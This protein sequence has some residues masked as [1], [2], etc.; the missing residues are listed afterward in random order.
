MLTIVDQR[1]STIDQLE[2]TLVEGE[3]MI[4]AIRA[5]QA[6][7]LVALAESRIDKV[8]GAKTL[9]EWVAARL[10]VAGDTAWAL[11][12]AA[13]LFAEHVSSA[14]RLAAAE[15]TFDRA[16]ATAKLA[17]S[18]ALE[19][20]LEASRGYDLSS[21]ARLTARHRRLSRSCEHASFR[22]RYLTIQPSLDD[23][24]W[25]LFG[26]L[27]ATDGRVIE[28]ALDRRA[29]SFPRVPGG[30][31]RSQRR[32]DAL[33]SLAQD[34]LDGSGSGAAGTTP[35]VTIFVDA[36]LA[37]STAGEA[38]AEIAAGPRI[39]P[40][41]LDRIM[42]DGSVQVIA[43]EGLRPI[44]ASPTTRVIAPTLRRFVLHRDGGCVVDGCSSRHRLQPHHVIP[45]SEGG[46]HDAE[47][48]ATLCWYHH[49]VAIHGSGF[50][51][52]PDSPPQR[53][54]LLSARTGP[55]PP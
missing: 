51:L 32:V 38:G 52:D 15:V 5:A 34:S 18:G 13:R 44:A 40:E 42:C 17:A 23:A 26:Q 37:A 12:E 6:T 3:L 27:P 19:R 55:D 54:R 41:T 50:R 46:G 47:N 10:D 33:T 53:R 30:G 31:G 1:R 43:T 21:V 11:V 7:A 16:R 20:L 49:H 45:R 22:D 39:G 8:D 24:S 25:K 2:Q 35:V 29:D 14:R 36:E 48:L 4:G 28:A 9:E